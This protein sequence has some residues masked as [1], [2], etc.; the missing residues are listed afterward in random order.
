MHASLQQGMQPLLPQNEPTHCCVRM[1]VHM[2]AHTCM[3]TLGRTLQA[4]LMRWLQAGECQ[5]IQ[6]EGGIGRMNGMK[7]DLRAIQE[8]MQHAAQRMRMRPLQ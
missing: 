5:R 7:H 8:H 4:S 1:H 2:R 3:C 6:E